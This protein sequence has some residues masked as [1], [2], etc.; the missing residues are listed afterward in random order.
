MQLV[1]Y[2]YE[3]GW[4]HYQSSANDLIIGYVDGRGSG[5]RGDDWLFSVHKRMGTVDVDD[6]ITAAKYGFLVNKYNAFNKVFLGFIY[7][8]PHYSIT[9][10]ISYDYVDARL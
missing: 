10:T 1:T 3:T 4:E 2:E 7:V 5:G 8:P 6:I 9:A